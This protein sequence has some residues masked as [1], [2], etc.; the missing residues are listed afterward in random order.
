[1]QIEMVRDCWELGMVERDGYSELRTARSRLTICPA[2]GYEWRLRDGLGRM[3]EGELWIDEIALQRRPSSVWVVITGADGWGLHVEV[4]H[5]ES[6]G[7]LRVVLQ[8]L[9]TPQVPSPDA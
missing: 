9:Q 2:L 7:D 8:D 4:P 6:Y 5:E 1:M 3:Q